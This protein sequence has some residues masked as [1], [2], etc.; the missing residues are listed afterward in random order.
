MKRRKGSDR[1]VW[2]VRREGRT[3]VR[4]AVGGEDVTEVGD[5]VERIGFVEPER[6]VNSSVLSDEEK[7]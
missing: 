7:S 5:D 6:H 2:R 4:V 3:L 1:L